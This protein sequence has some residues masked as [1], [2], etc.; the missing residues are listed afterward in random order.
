MA[1]AD[2]NWPKLMSLAVHELRTPATVV[3]G[4]LRMLLKDRAGPLTE[5]QRR[6]MVEA[7][8]S[9]GRLSQLLAEMSDLAHIEA[10][11][12]P[13]N[14]HPFDLATLVREVVDSLP[15]GEDLP[16]VAIRDDASPATVEGDPARFRTAIGA[17][18]TSVR[19]ELPTASTIVVGRTA[20]RRDGRGNSTMIAIGEEA[21]VSDLL[22]ASDDGSPRFDEWRG[23]MG[24]S[25][26]VA[27]RV[28]EASGGRLIVLADRPRGGVALL[29][30]LR[31]R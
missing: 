13:M 23:G 2:A 29:L 12:A 22:A 4:Y 24:L 20:H 10:G 16:A 7:E 27:R 1:D 8:K 30:P 9:C 17:L 15:H 21:T 31:D 26:P 3:A 11:D 28:V 6:L 18:I 19:R 25:L 14:R 5:A